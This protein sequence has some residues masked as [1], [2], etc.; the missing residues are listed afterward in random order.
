M[1]EKPE[2]KS[3]EVDIYMARLDHPLKSEVQAVREI[4]RGVNPGI[5]EQVKWNAPSFSYRD[6][7]VTF[8]LRAT[9]R[10]HLVWHNSHI[11]EIES[12]WLEGDYK[13]RRMSYLKGMDEVKARRGELERIIQ[14]LVRLIEGEAK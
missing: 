5:T 7:L 12:D 10:V 9:D 2:N 1:A 11:A 6:Y 8:N 13:D 14:D 4:I 3:A